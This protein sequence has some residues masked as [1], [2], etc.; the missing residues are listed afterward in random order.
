MADGNLDIGQ[1]TVK[2]K[3]RDLFG[4]ESDM[5]IMGFPDKSDRVP[6]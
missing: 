5:E 2:Y 3:V 4:I 1:P 6:E